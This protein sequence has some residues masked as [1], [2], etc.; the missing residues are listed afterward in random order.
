MSKRILIG[1]TEIAGCIRDFGRA[2]Q[3]AGYNTTTVIQYYN[4]FYQTLSYTYNLGD[5]NRFK[6]IPKIGK[7]YSS[8]IRWIFFFVNVWKFDY[9]I[10][11]W[12]STYLP[13]R[14]DQF[15]LKLLGKP[16]CIV[17]CGDDIR[18][19]PIALRCEEEKYGIK[20][21]DAVSRK[22]YLDGCGQKDFIKKIFRSTISNLLTKNIFSSK[23]LSTLTLRPFYKIFKP[24]YIDIS[25][26]LVKNERITIVHAPTDS[27][28]KSSDFI[29]ETLEEV[30]KEGYDFDIILLKNQPNDMVLH[31][32]AHAHIAIDQI[33]GL[34]GRFAL[35]AMISGCAVLG[36]NKHYYENKC[37][38]IPVI[39]IVFDKNDLKKKIITLLEDPGLIK[40]LGEKGKK[41][42]KKYHTGSM[43][44]SQMVNALE[45]RNPPDQTPVWDS[46]RELLSYCSFWYEKFFIRLLLHRSKN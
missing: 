13:F 38:E 10:Y 36:G 27:V 40:E 7:F 30:K 28:V 39:D 6:N 44:V 31:T 25:S 33:S 21:F 8:F 46:K 17:Y 22:K 32:L 24:F 19:R 18:F 11:I 5:Y 14:L 23:S 16:F 3:E 43:T 41:Y 29:I 26:N 12:Y 37:S 45:G 42:I 1:I 20:R 2:F 34:P 15:L 35:E 4:P 9:F